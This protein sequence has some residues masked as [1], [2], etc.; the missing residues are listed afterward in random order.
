MSTARSA[1]PATV[2]VTIPP[3]PAFLR[4]LRLSASS[5]ATD[6]DFDVEDVEDLR[7]AVDELAALLVAGEGDE[8][9]RVRFTVEGD[10]LRIEGE[11]TGPAPE[12]ADALHPIAR[13]L[14]AAFADEHRYEV[15]DDGRRFL[16]RKAGPS[17]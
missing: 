4:L 13:E 14:V 5:L 8:P 17:S 2:E 16:L 11:R 10:G 12:G 1:A 9:I 3:A 7:V 6:L 15:D